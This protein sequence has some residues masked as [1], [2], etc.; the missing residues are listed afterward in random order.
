MSGEKP[1]PKPPGIYRMEL[2]LAIGNFMNLEPG[3][4]FLVYSALQGKDDACQRAAVQV[5]SNLFRVSDIGTSLGIACRLGPE[6]GPADRLLFEV[7]PDVAKTRLEL[8]VE[9]FQAHL[10]L[11]PGSG[12]AAID[13]VRA[14]AA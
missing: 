13:F 5:L 3:L 11:K 8:L 2:N 10:R 9:H 12:E 6:P 4:R 1:V 14:P 7:E